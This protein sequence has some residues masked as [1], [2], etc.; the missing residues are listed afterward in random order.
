[1]FTFWSW[2]A[3]FPLDTLSSSQLPKA[4]VSWSGWQRAWSSDWPPG[5]C[6]FHHGRRGSQPRLYPQPL[7]FE[8]SSG[9]HSGHFGS[10]SINYQLLCQKGLVDSEPR[11]WRRGARLLGMRVTEGP[12]VGRRVSEVWEGKQMK[13]ESW[14]KS[15]TEPGPVAYG[16]FYI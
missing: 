9:I 13:A 2:L 10:R 15:L 5:P 12:N 6:K 11:W 16:G 3:Y 7:R 1:M 4:E 14:S 8:S